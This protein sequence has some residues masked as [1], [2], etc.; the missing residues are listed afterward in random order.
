MVLTVKFL[1]SFR[2]FSGTQ[3]LTFDHKKCSTVKE[4]IYQLDNRLPE[5][6]STVM[7]QL[8]DPRSTTLI[9]VNGKEI[10][11]LN[12]LETKL[13]DGDEVVLIPFVHGG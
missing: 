11:L 2:H 8:E 9:L 4:L 13:E 12:G 10:G 1:G 3:K 5:P 7:K 6:E